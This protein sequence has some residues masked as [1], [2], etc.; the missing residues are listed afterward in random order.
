[1]SSESVESTLEDILEKYK[2]AFSSKIFPDESS[3][4]DDLMLVFG[5]TQEIKSLNKQYW[6][7]E[8]GKCWERIVIETCKQRCKYFGSRIK[9]EQGEF[10]DFTI[11]KTAIDTK[12]RI[13]SGDSGTLAKFESDGNDLLKRGYEPVMLILRK[14]NLQSAINACIKGGWTVKTGND[15][16][17]YI[18]EVTGFDLKSWLGMKRNHYEIKDDLET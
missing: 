4:V 11:G 7:R 17:N 15:T 14:D 12:Y 13:G 3:D 2:K 5:L 6:G 8:L 9:K 10:C 16:Y 18:N 1:M